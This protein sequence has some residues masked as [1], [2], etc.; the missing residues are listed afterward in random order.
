MPAENT[1]SGRDPLALWLNQ[2]REVLARYY[3]ESAHA[4]LVIDLGEDVPAA[5]FVVTPVVD[6]SL[7]LPRPTPRE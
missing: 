7:C 3:P 2:G 1:P 4:V 5:Q 6:A